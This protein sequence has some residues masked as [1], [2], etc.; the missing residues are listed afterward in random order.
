MQP[1]KCDDRC[2]CHEHTDPKP[3]YYNRRWD[4]HACSDP[5]C[6]NAHGM[7]PPQITSQSPQ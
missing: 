1:H 2:V 5:E 7:K 3:L 6:A 4:E